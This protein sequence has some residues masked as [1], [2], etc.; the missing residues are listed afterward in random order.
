MAKTN[1]IETI[2]NAT[3][4]CEKTII[5]VLAEKHDDIDDMEWNEILLYAS[6][7]MHISVENILE[8]IDERN[9]YDYDE[10]EREYQQMM[11]IENE[12]TNYTS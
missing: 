9:S 3:S 5:D 6:N 12:E 8:K 7:A 10:A 1:I 11:S 4:L 2:S